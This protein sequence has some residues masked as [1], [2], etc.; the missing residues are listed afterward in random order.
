[1]R[2][3]S[4]PWLATTRGRSTMSGGL[5]EEMKVA[6]DLLAIKQ[7]RVLGDHKF[8]LEFDSDVDRMRIVDGS[9]WRHRHQLS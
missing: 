4:S 9:L 6:W 3:S 8:M 2:S 5:F 1:V 7:A